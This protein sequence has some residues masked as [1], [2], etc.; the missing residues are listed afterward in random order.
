MKKLLV[1]AVAALMFVSGAALACGGKCT[2]NRPVLDHISIPDGWTIRVCYCGNT[3]LTVWCDAPD[4]LLCKTC[5]PHIHV[6]PPFTFI[7]TDF[8]P[9]PKF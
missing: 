2:C 3:N 9:N 1:F 5:T 8:T 4:C 6:F 7:T